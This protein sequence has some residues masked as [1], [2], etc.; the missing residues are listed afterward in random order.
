MFGSIANQ[1]LSKPSFHGFAISLGSI[2]DCRGVD[3][4]CDVLRLN[5]GS[6]KN[7]C[8]PCSVAAIVVSAGLSGTQESGL[9]T[10][11]SL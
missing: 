9:T 11:W 10:E 6:D 1:A 5:A 7:K 2:T 4:F 3:G 8:N